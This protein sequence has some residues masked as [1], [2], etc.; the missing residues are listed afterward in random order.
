[1]I[2]TMFSGLAVVA[3]LSV[4]ASG[5][6]VSG[7]VDGRDFLS[8]AKRRLAQSTAKA[9]AGSQQ[10]ARPRPCI[11]VCSS[12]EGISPWLKNKKRDLGA[13]WHGIARDQQRVDARQPRGPGT[14]RGRPARMTA[15]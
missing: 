14:G 7:D 9:N 8:V 13:A 10:R 3:T 4:A 2:R 1:M 11:P 12:T 5:H 15:I 6:A